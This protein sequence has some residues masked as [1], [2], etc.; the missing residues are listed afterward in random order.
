[1]RRPVPLLTVLAALLAVAG[2]SL[3]PTYRRPTVDIPAAF[4]ATPTT[5]QVAWPSVRWWEGFGS[6][7]LDALV[8]EARAANQNLAAA[9]ARIVQ[10]DA[11]VR[12]NGA[13]LLPALNGQGTYNYVREGTGTVVGVPS[14]VPGTPR[15][16]DYRTYAAELQVS[17]DLDFWRRNRA[18][19][20]SAEAATLATRFDQE[21]VALDTFTSVANT[22]FQLLAAQDRVR[23]AERNLR[24]AEAILAAYRARLAAGT[25][26]ALDLSQQEALVAGQ[27][28]LIPNLRSQAEQER[29]ALG[30][31][32]GQ[33]PERLRVAGGSLD[34]LHLPR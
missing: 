25:A 7:E 8:T 31:L 23:I 6:P 27:R 4:A 14:G 20:R 12:I 33:P 34:P 19:F 22:Y 3:G 13:P 9:A 29:I 30:I 5:A 18:L 24:S 11:Q 2:C 16:F 10:A 17:Y 28:A 15:Y 26:S 32:T 1:M 21:T